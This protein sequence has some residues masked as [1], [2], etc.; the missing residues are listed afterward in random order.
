MVEFLTV[1]QS[2]TPQSWQ[3]RPARQMPEYPD[4]AAL[5]AVLAG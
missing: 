4:K 1:A 2:W 3:D 5:D